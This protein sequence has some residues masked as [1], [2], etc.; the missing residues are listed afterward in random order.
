VL[1]GCGIIA[2]SNKNQSAWGVVMK[3][4]SADDRLLFCGGMRHTFSQ[5]QD[6]THRAL[7]RFVRKLEPGGVSHG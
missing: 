4:K 6:L 7:L 2:V 1:A 5:A 3:I